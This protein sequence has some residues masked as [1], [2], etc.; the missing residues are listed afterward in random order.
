MIPAMDNLPKIIQ[1]GMGAGVSCWSLA[2]AVSRKGQLGVVAG[3][4]LDVILARQL[5]LGDTTG[6]LRTALKAFPFPAMAERILERYF[7]EGGKQPGTRFKSKPM[8]SAEPSQALNELTVVSNYVE[9]FLAKMGHSNPV[10]I[11]YLEKIQLPTAP[12]LYGAMLAGVGYVLMGA[13]IPM[14]I[15]GIM[16]QLSQGVAVELALDVKGAR[17]GE[18]QTTVFD[19]AEFLGGE[20]PTLTRPNFLAI[21]STHSVASILLRKATGRIDGFIIEGPTAGGHNAPPRAKGDLS[22]EGEPVYGERDKPDLDAFRGFER[23]FWMAGGLAD[24]AGLQAAIDQGAT[25]IQV[26]TAFAYTEE[27]G[28]LAEYKQHVLAQSREGK[29]HV[30]TDPIAS[31]TGFPFKVVSVEGTISD[32]AVSEART[33]VCDLGYLRHGYLR[34]DSTLGWR[35]PSEPVEDYVKK[36][37][38]IEDTIGRK[39]VCNGLLANIGL[40][41]ELKDG[42]REL[43]ILTS[44]DDAANVARFLK[45][46]AD[47]YS[48]SDVIDSLLG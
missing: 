34:E 9:V 36:G 30:H 46:G 10:G 26:G 11:N 44:G 15:P 13:G 29:V 45:D 40:A 42:T 25:G 7:V 39:C 31:P 19:P 3:T 12:A 38:D 8:P 18:R 47:S 24:R 43:P 23:P 4:A 16:D 48:A 6:K 41:Q 22:A 5:Q 27:S 17:G 32:N 14:A 21:V 2:N 35:C 20:A 28:I 1:G 37:G 33:R